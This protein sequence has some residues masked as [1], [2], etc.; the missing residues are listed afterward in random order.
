MSTRSCFHLVALPFT[1][2]P[3]SHPRSRP[4]RPQPRASCQRGDLFSRRFIFEEL[5]APLHSQGRRQ[6]PHG[7]TGLREPLPQKSPCPK[8]PPP[9]STSTWRG[10]RHVSRT[11]MSEPYHA[12][13]LKPQIP[14]RHP[15]CPWTNAPAELQHRGLNATATGNT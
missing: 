3:D 15:F 5:S 7:R 10:V 11:A 6:N 13:K 14:A 8:T 12:A 1:T 2:Q 9:A 4:A